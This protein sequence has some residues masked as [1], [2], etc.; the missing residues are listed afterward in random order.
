MRELFS[1]YSIYSDIV[2]SLTHTCMKTAAEE[3]EL[4]MG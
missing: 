2:R 4:A 3:L 1:I